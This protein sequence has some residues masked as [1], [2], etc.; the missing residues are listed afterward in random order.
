MVLLHVVVKGLLQQ[1]SIV[2]PYR[3][4]THKRQLK[5]SVKIEASRYPDILH[6]SKMM[7]S[8]FPIMHW[9][10][11]FIRAPE[12]SKLKKKK[13]DPLSRLTLLVQCGMVQKE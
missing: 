3:F 6:V 8:R 11:P 10:M 7:D 5:R 2:F 13:K 9:P 4:G 1:F 12:N